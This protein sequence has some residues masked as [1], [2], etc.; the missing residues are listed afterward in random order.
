MT[1][2]VETIADVVTEMREWQTGVLVKADPASWPDRIAAAHTQAL[3]AQQ[4][5]AVAWLASDGTGRVIDAK[6]KNAGSRASATGSATAIYSIPLYTSP[7]PAMRADGSDWLDYAVTPAEKAQRAAHFDRI[8]MRAVVEAL[9]EA[10]ELLDAQSRFIE[11]YRTS[12]KCPNAVAEKAVSL[13]HRRNGL[14]PNYYNKGKIHAALAEVAKMLGE[15][16]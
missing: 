2:H 12:G 14:L 11:E 10:G 1:N 9:Q 6:A 8:A 7:T 5:K 3:D 13:L 16:K 15:G 4:S